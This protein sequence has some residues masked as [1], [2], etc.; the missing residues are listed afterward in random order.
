MLD[1]TDWIDSAARHRPQHIFLRVPSGTDLTYEGLR[2]EAARFASALNS[3]GDAV[4][5]AL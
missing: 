5:E 1:P 3:L 2:E 4:R